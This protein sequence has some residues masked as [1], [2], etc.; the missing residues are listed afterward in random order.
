M[1]SKDVA[2]ALGRLLGEK[3]VKAARLRKGAGLSLGGGR[4]RRIGPGVNKGIPQQAPAAASANW[5]KARSMFGRM[6]IPPQQAPASAPAAAP[7]AAPKTAASRRGIEKKAIGIGT[8]LLLA[9]FAPQ[10]YKG[11]KGAWGGLGRGLGSWLGL[12]QRAGAGAGAGAGADAG[13]GGPLY[14]A[15]TRSMFA[16]AG[17][18]P[19]AYQQRHGAMGD[20]LGGMRMRG[21]Q[22]KNWQAIANAMLL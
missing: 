20:V 6:G 7:A 1:I 22:S 15:H 19:A 18:N 9:S 8:G 11:L 3:H 4:A 14:G 13:K 2:G 5:E 21:A 16:R 12:K 10:I 17:I